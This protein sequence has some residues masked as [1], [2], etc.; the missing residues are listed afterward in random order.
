[1]PSSRGSSC[2]GESRAETDH[3]SLWFFTCCLGDGGR[4]LGG[5]SWEQHALPTLI[6][7]CNY[8]PLTPNT[9]HAAGVQLTAE[10]GKQFVRAESISVGGFSLI[11]N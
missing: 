6:P 8:S 1:M 11:I 9:C 2:P 7:R 5:D 10:L 4:E 3:V